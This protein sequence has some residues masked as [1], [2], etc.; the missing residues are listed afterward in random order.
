[1]ARRF[2]KGTLN[3]STVYY[4]TDNDSFIAKIGDCIN[5]SNLTLDFNGTLFNAGQPCTPVYDQTYLSNQATGGSADG[6][7]RIGELTYT[8]T[9]IPATGV[10][11]LVLTAYVLARD[12]T[13][14]KTI[15]GVAQGSFVVPNTDGALHQYSTTV[16]LSAGTNTIK[17]T[18]IADTGYMSSYSIRVLVG[19][20]STVTV[21]PSTTPTPTT[22]PTNTA[23][24][25]KIESY[26]CNS[27]ILQYKFLS[28]N[29]ATGS[30]SIPGIFAGN[31]SIGTLYTHTFPSDARTN[32]VVTG[33]ATQGGLTINISF[34]TS[35][36]LS[37]E[38]TP[39][40]TSTPTQT[41]TAVSG[42]NRV[43]IVGN[44]IT[45]NT[46]NGKNWGMAASSADKDYYHLLTNYLKT[47]NP[48]VIVREFGDFNLT[49]GIVE[50]SHWEEFYWR[51][52]DTT[53]D[54]AQGGL[55]RYDPV[56]A[57]KPD[58]II[59]RIAE[60]ITDNSHNLAFHYKAFV[61]RLKSQN[62]TAQVVL[63]TSVWN[64]STTSA[65]ITSVGNQN[66]WPVC[67]LGE[68]PGATSGD[69]FHPDDNAMQTIANRIWATIPKNVQTA[70]PT[71]TYSGPIGAWLPYANDPSVWSNDLAT[72]ENSTIKLQY[73]KSIGGVLWWAGLKSN[74]R[75]L[76]QTHLRD[77][78]PYWDT[79]RSYGAAWYASP[80]AN[81]PL[82]IDG[83][84]NFG[85]G[86]DPV[87]GGSIN[88]NLGDGSE[89]IKAAKINDPS[90]GTVLCM[91]V[92]PKQWDFVN[93]PSDF[94]TNHEFWIAADNTQGHRMQ[95]IVE[96]RREG[97]QAANTWSGYS[98]EE[99]GVYP[100]ASL[101]KRMVLVNGQDIDKYPIET[102]GS[103][104]NYYTDNYAIFSGNDDL[105]Q[106][107]MVYTPENNCMGSGQPASIFGN[108]GESTDIQCGY[109]QSKPY[110]NLDSPGTY[111]LTIYTVIGTY[112]DC[113]SRVASLPQ[114]SQSF[115]F[116]FT[117][118][119]SLQHGWSNGNEPF[120][121]EDGKWTLY[122]GQG[123]TDGGQT[124]YRGNIASPF[125]RWNASG[126]TT[127][128]IIAAVTGGA[129]QLLL[130]WKKVKSDG[131]LEEFSKPF[132]VIG[133]GLERAY[134]VPTNHANWTG[135]INQVSIQ[136]TPT[137]PNGAK[138]KPLR[139]RKV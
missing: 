18:P 63:T 57:W 39:T 30:A 25:F 79:G 37:T 73:R 52:D 108:I 134:T 24:Q 132:S 97:V 13:V 100:I 83:I 59:M 87:W 29:T 74:N 94:L 4:Y 121:V 58:L 38:N 82:T 137:I 103:P 67:D 32:R 66:G 64:Q 5:P 62:P 9:N 115:D 106:G 26:D 12:F 101:H 102:V 120:K 61:D 77:G 88:S 10:Y 31:I 14:A 98:Q 48:N 54:I 47:L 20:T 17:L 40:Q 1:M 128:E 112:N 15:N 104:Q 53:L 56:A 19:N 93:K 72:L 91:Q 135:V 28:S 2:F 107:F 89:V 86:Y 90:R 126:I 122:I 65:I 45:H 123:H 68:I 124:S 50:G 7:N 55:A 117:N 139:I 71:Q 133:D 75:N 46:W 116:D 114:H 44:S 70:T 76:I 21:L 34:T 127:I 6:N 22:T 51:L 113:K 111:E 92:R 8:I 11:S 33:T 118:L 125:R 110:R 85:I 23:F 130:T 69:S 16:V 131:S 3:G 35:C 43:F 119:T 80:A 60:N 41:A 136:A 95:V 42:Y 138:F 78:G 99:P 129:N 109:M 27:G 49:Y 84:T 105:S 36:N 81:T 96:P